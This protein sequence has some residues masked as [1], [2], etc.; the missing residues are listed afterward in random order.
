M[1]INR[2]WWDDVR[3]ATHEVPLRSVKLLFYEFARTRAALFIG[4]P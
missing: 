1:L 4:M 3:R 2:Q